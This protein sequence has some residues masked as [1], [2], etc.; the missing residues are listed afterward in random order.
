MNPFAMGFAGLSVC[1][2][3]GWDKVIKGRK[4]ENMDKTQSFSYHSISGKDIH[5]FEMFSSHHGCMKIQV[6][7][8]NLALSL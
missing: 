3:L 4:S 2:K 6:I 5:N 7:V 8:W 1:E